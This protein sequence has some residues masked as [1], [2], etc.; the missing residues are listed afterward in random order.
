MPIVNVSKGNQDPNELVKKIKIYLYYKVQSF[1]R[2][3][4][5]IYLDLSL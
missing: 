5:R 2:Q 3:Y 1:V 4:L